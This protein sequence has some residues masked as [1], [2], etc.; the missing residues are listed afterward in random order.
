MSVS[1]CAC[2]YVFFEKKGPSW[3]GR[4]RD[5]KYLCTTIRTGMYRLVHARVCFKRVCVRACVCERALS[6]CVCVCVSISVC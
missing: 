3:S 5:S 6:I 1:E 4:P 2:V